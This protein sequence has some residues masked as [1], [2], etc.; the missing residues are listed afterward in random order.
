MTIELDISLEGGEVHGIP[1]PVTATDLVL[2]NA[3]CR[4]VGYSLREASG[5]VESAKEGAV[6]APGAG[7][8]IVSIT[9][10]AAGTYAVQWQVELAGAAAAAEL[11]NFKLTSS[12]GDIVVS[13]N[14]AAAGLY[15]QVSAD[16]TVGAAGSISVVAI[17]AGTAG[18]T[19]AAQISLD[20]DQPVDA[21]VEIQD[22]AN[23]LDEVSLQAGFASNQW[24]GPEGRHVRG[25]IK[26]H[27]VQGTVTGIVY[28]RFDR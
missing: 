3:P 26:L 11:N 8:T 18:V 23:P 14:P 6:V 1:V 10:L 28:A 13:V 17:G 5:S 12:A 7:A 4:Y 22:S 2:L 27:V 21:I 25:Q 15:A 24:Y 9:G 19:Y 20:Q 16:V